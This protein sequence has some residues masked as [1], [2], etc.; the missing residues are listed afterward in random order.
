MTKSH[1]PLE[2]LII[3]FLLVVTVCFFSYWGYQSVIY[4]LGEMFN[5]PTNSTVFDILIGVLGMVS[6]ALVFAGTAF[7]STGK[8]SSRS[9]ITYGSLG[10]IVK[11][12][13]DIYNGIAVFSIT[14]PDVVEIY[15]LQKLASAL[16]WQLFQL[17]FWVFVIF[18]FAYLAKKKFGAIP[19]PQI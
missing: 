17:A 6:G 8:L 5:V 13:L 18:Y 19:S 11:N 7:W 1:N 14:R 15:H 9:L 3:T 16:G 2:T 12:V 10:F 4:I